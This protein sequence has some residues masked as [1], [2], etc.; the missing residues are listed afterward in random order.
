MKL[1]TLFLLVSSTI[2]GQKMEVISENF[3][4]YQRH[5]YFNTVKELDIESEEVF[6]QIQDKNYV[7]VST[8]LK[9]NYFLTDTLSK[10]FIKGR[11]IKEKRVKNDMNRISDEIANDSNSLKIHSNL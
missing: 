5:G 8:D 10:I 6:Y 2:F 7:S 1:L 9:I 4:E 11:Q 3:F